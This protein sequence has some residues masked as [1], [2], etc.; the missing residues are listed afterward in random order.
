MRVDRKTVQ[1]DIRFE[2]ERRADEI[3]HRRATELARHLARL[4]DLYFRARALAGKPGVGGLAAA[5]KALEQ[6]AKVLGL[7]KSSAL[8]PLADALVKIL[9]AD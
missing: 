8:D 2:A 3:E 4:N 7:E 6:Y 5:A 1:S 9:D